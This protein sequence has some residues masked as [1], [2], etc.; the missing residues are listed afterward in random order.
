[1]LNH[2]DHDFRFGFRV[3]GD[4]ARKHFHIADH[5]CRFGLRGYTADA[6]AEADGLA[7]YFALEGT[8]DQL[9]G[10]RGGGVEDVEAGPVCVVAGG[11]EGV[12]AVPEE[13]G[14]VGEVAVVGRGRLVVRGEGREG[15]EKAFLPEAENPFYQ[16][17]STEGTFLLQRPR[18]VGP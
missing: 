11:G 9:R 3:T 6:P 4:M 1:M 12:E 17:S 2:R 13:G 15:E 10:G 7:S 16:K 14:G 8:E 18:A 5:L